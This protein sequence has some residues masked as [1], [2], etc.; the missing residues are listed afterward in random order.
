LLAS[1]VSKRKG[2]ALWYQL[3]AGDDD[4]ATFFYY[5]SAAVKNAVPRSR[6][7]PE[8]SAEQ[9]GVAGFT[10][11][12]FRALFDR[13][14]SDATVVVEDYHRLARSTPLHAMLAEALAEIPRTAR[15]LIS[16][17]GAPPRAYAR[18]FANRLLHVI[19]G[20]DLRLSLDETRKIVAM[21]GFLE[22][23]AIEDLHAR[24]NGWATGIVLLARRYRRRGIDRAAVS[25][26]LDTVFE[27]FDSEIYAPASAAVRR[28]LL[29]TAWLT[30][31]DA[32]MAAALCG[33]RD[34]A[35]LLQSECL[36]HGFISVTAGARHPFQ[37]HDLFREFLV[38]RA[39]ETAPQDELEVLMRT[40]AD[41]LA[42]GGAVE[43][44]FSLYADS[45]DSD[46]ATRLL[47]A[48]APQLLKRQRS[49]MLE[50]WLAR[51][52]PE[53][54]RA[55]PWL[56][57]WKSMVSL[58]RDPRAGRR[59][60]QTVLAAF[61]RRGDTVGRVS[62]ATSIIQSHLFDFDDIQGI[63][64]WLDV[65]GGFL[66]RQSAFEKPE[67]ELHILSA[68]GTALLFRAPAHPDLERCCDR[69]LELVQQDV[70]AG[71]RVTAGSF[72]ML[73]CGWLGDVEQ[74]LPILRPIGALVDDP[75]VSAAER[76]TWRWWRSQIGL[77]TERR[78]AALAAADRLV[79][80][81]EENGLVYLRIYFEL[82]RV[83][84]HLM[85]G[86]VGAAEKF[87][88]SAER[89]TELLG[90]RDL[91]LLHYLKAT[92]AFERDDLE[93]AE[94]H[95]REALSF[96][97]RNGVV[98]PIYV[99]LRGLAL[100]LADRGRH[101]EAAARAHESATQLPVTPRID[102]EMRLLNAYVAL[103]AA[104]F[105]RARRELADAPAAGRRVGFA[106]NVHWP[107]RALAHVAA[108]ALQEGIETAHFRALVGTLEL[109]P[110]SQNIERWP[111]PVRIRTL[112]E[113]SV[114]LDDRPLTFSTKAPKKPL[115]LL[116]AVVA[117]GGMRVPEARLAEILW[118]GAEADAATQA[119]ASTLHRL[120]DL[121]GEDTIERHKGHL[122]L[123]ARMCWVDLF[124]LDACLRELQ[125]ACARGQIDSVMAVGAR[126]LDLYQGGF[127]ERDSDDHWVLGTREALRARFSRN[128]AGAA[129]LLAEAHDHERA[130]E[131]LIEALEVEPLSEELYVG[132]M[133]SYAATNRAA[134]ALLAFKRGRSRLRAELGVEPS[135]ETVR[136]ADAIQAGEAVA[137][138]RTA[139][140]AGR[141]TPKPSS[142][143]RSVR[144]LSSRFR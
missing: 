1:Y 134:D 95:C 131:W 111:W 83:A 86:R 5:L 7:L 81:A 26:G 42:S 19:E 69:L 30:R 84:A 11:L 18:A 40:S 24:T 55:Q 89:L 78:E 8:L 98:V 57:Y 14:G 108:F 91:A 135:A 99:C 50:S 13:L 142:K 124:A 47:L 21:E 109:R 10:R 139:G 49:Q 65:V 117:L 138:A 54:F 39:R 120:R 121:V 130:I 35:R 96:A 62:V 41:L 25:P 132:L 90:S 107:P 106:N 100:I 60:M 3:D 56:A 127:L 93:T 51:L 45:G 80:F 79:P 38:S 77:L 16:S 104:D 125:D 103:R 71:A 4:P 143:S 6:P 2:R 105:A 28:M 123:N 61:E 118:P 34:S 37:Y 110:P 48:Q 115:E 31:F 133:H 43:D 112:G 92:V 129:R 137:P 67:A 68:Y 128:I 72:L 32:S 136:L 94:R 23:D 102:F 12:Y 75:Q 126:A 66:A 52:P 144:D 53:A 59:A 113:F 74:C 22:P 17:R 82:C 58:L 15:L 116:Q 85:Y 114:T 76:A 27:Y 140:S 36:R 44:A 20:D 9:V 88:H 101:E 33:R 122:A 87:L 46:A 97:R 64:P 63:D 141:P 119:L 70:D 29:R 73:K